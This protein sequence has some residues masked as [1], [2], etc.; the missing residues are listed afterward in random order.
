MV[1]DW[2]DDSVGNWADDW[3]EIQAAEKVSKLGNQMASMMATRMGNW[4]AVCWV[5]WMVG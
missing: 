1:V 2:A 4:K 3:E 5:A